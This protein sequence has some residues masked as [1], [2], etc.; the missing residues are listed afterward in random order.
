MKCSISDSLFPI[1][2]DKI[3]EACENA[4]EFIKN[5]RDRLF[6]K[7]VNKLMDRRFFKPSTRER[8]RKIVIDRDCS[9]LHFI[10]WQNAYIYDK[11]TAKKL[12][13]SLEAMSIDQD[14]AYLSKEDAEF[15]QKFS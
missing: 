13:N 15:V 14:L 10:P 9:T 6:E 12:N 1:H 11:I 5:E 2:K 4:F 7:E 8:A 3:K